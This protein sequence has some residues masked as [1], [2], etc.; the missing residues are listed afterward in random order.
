MLLGFRWRIDFAEHAAGFLGVMFFLV[1]LPTSS[2]IP[3]KDMAFEHRMYLPLA[4]VVAAVVTGA[5]AVLLRWNAKQAKAP[6][7]LIVMAALLATTWER[8][9]LYAD[10]VAL[11]RDTIAKAPENPRSRN[12]LGYS[13]LVRGEVSAAHA[14][15]SEAMRL[16]PQNAGAYANRGEAYMRER[17]FADAADAL[18]GRSTRE[19]S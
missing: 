19:R 1:L 6:L 4:A 14:E 10:P 15:F 18:P 9:G 12:A 5:N 2:F 8:N 13:L 16:D 7:A 11:W 17:K 3:I